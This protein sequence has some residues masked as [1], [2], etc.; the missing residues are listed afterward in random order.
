[1]LVTRRRR[2]ASLLALIAL[3]AIGA[4]TTLCFLP[5]KY[6]RI[7][8]PDGKE[9]AFTI[10]DDT[11]KSTI[12]NIKPVY[13][14]LYEL[15]ILTTKTIWVL[16]TNEPNIPEGSSSHG[17]T[18]SDR[19]YRSFILELHNKGF[20]IASH[21]ARGVST[22]R[23]ETED[24]IGRFKQIIG[25]YP[26]THINHGSNRE[27]LYWG[28]S[29]L[30]F[31][32]LRILYLLGGG[33]RDYTGHIHGSEYWWGDVALRNIA[34]VRNLT[35]EDINTLKINPSMP[36]H[37]PRKPYVNW[38]FSSSNGSDAQAFNRLLSKK[39]VDRLE[40]E[41]MLVYCIHPFC[42]RFCLR[43]FLE[44]NHKAFTGRFGF[45]KWLVCPCKRNSRLSERV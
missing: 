11:D 20:E 13:D 27:N 39:N 30:D 36:Y 19:D 14:C 41:K 18:L 45:Q 31:W 22:K 42:K 6:P 16:Q 23:F 10:V 26:H 9:F 8:W 7:A 33:E 32:P 24:A 37:N 34:Y 28:V 4:L 21:G 35:Y 44:H 2:L 1:M 40:R 43:R 38:W 5:P 25:H 17:Q 15:G 3:S 29:R 12:E